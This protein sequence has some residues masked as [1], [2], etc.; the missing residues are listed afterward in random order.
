MIV[1]EVFTITMVGRP[2]VGKSTMFNYLVGENLAMTDSVAGLTRDR[3][4]KKV[5][6]LGG[7]VKVVDT[8]GWYS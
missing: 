8:P 4:E 7:E 2:N 3:K 5:E 1:R 6:L